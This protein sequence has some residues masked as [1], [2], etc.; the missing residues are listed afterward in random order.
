MEKNRFLY[1]A[2][3]QGIQNFIFQTNKLQDIIGASE[4]VEEICT[5]KFAE[6]IGKRQEDLAN[7]RNAII[8]AAG[9]VKYVFENREDCEKVVLTFPKQISTFAPGITISQA[10]V[11]FSSQDD[12]SQVV[13][14]LEERLK[15]QRNYP[16][17]SLTTGLMGI[18]RSRQTGLPV[19][20][21]KGEEHLDAATKAKKSM[22]EPTRN[23]LCKKAFDQYIA[24]KQF[25][26]NIDDITD[27]NSWIAIIHA[28][29]NGLG[30][31]VQQVGKDIT[32]FKEFSRNLDIAT[33]SAAQQAYNAIYDKIGNVNV[34][35]LRPIVLGGD[36]LT[37]ICRADLAIPYTQAFIQ[38]FEDETANRLRSQIDKA[39]DH[40]ENGGLTACAGIAFVKSSYPFSFAYELAEQLCSAA[41]KDAKHSDEIK[42]GKR[43]AQS[44][45]MFHKV[46]DSFTQEYDA[47]VKRELQPQDTIS[48]QYGPYYL[49]PANR[50]RATIDELLENVKSFDSKEGN[51][52]KSHL[53][54]WM[55]LLHADENKA[56][57]HLLR[58]KSNISD[59]GLKQIV[60]QITTPRKEIS[61][62]K[63]MRFFMVYDALAIHT[64]N[65][66]TTKE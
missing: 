7:D 5:T 51:A 1:G 55:S 64:I 49:K 33:Q 62:D 8:N 38:A 26:Y 30:Q 50:N 9:N 3:V 27:K 18:E 37:I 54:Q 6:A 23:I 56:Q 32:M 36:D 28:D 44:C 40:R 20:E 41:K 14:R 15:A 34:I 39:F 52:V 60:E 48:F 42:Q 24:N 61:D 53:R 2:A 13:D 22:A 21:I 63:E 4:L 16:M 29:G 43:L 31:I 25:P 17:R 47:I 35:P 19:V 10:V 57:Q 11:E 65:N 46:Q 59:K 45:L 66:Q 58:L 12:F